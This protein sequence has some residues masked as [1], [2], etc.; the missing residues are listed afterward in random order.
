MA[1][2][3]RNTISPFSEADVVAEMRND[4]FS[5]EY[6]LCSDFETDN[7]EIDSCSQVFT[8]LLPIDS[9]DL[10]LVEKLIFLLYF[11][12]LKVF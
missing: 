4:L 9:I 11:Q 6:N 7:E 1:A 5:G 3:R 2:D 8:P 12:M 10:D